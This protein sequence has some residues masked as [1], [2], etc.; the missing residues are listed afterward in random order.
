MGPKW[1][2]SEP[3]MNRKWTVSE[4]EVNRKWTGSE[5]EMNQ[6]WT[7]FGMGGIYKRRT[8]VPYDFY[9]LKREK[10]KQIF[11]QNLG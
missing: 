4:L 5:P 2:G 7:G 8:F 9:S 6:K 1:A 3:E 10:C 11:H